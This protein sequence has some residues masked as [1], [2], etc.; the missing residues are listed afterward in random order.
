MIESE[1]GDMAHASILPQLLVLISYDI[2]LFS[3]RLEAFTNVFDQV[4]SVKLRSY[5]RS[6]G[7]QTNFPTWA[8][9]RRERSVEEAP[10]AKNSRQ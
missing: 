1:M 2:Q 7:R 9:G 5:G 4:R 10:Q 8:A 6:K 3:K